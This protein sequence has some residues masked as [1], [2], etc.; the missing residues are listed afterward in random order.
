MN[1]VK[2]VTFIKAFLF[3]TALNQIST[4]TPPPLHHSSV[5]FLKCNLHASFQ[6]DGSSFGPPK[7]LAMDGF[8][9]FLSHPF[10]NG[11][12]EV[13]DKVNTIGIDRLGIYYS[14]L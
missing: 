6:V 2:S 14:S 11:L 12:K 8:K 3:F 7:S 1:Q 5:G 4:S 13:V 10:S 9:S